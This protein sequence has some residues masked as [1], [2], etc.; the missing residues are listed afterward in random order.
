MKRMT[1]FRYSKDSSTVSTNELK[2]GNIFESYPQISQ[3]GIQGEPGTVFKL[4]SG[5]YPI[6]LGETGIYEIDLEDRGFIHTINF[7]ECTAFSKY[8]LGSVLLIDI[9]YEG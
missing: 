9:V 8:Q 1:Q 2:F 7:L 6:T 4:N 5:D 3:L